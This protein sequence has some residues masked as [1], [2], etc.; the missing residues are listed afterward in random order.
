MSEIR[1][2]NRRACGAA[3]RPA[4][5]VGAGVS[6]V[7]IGTV[8]TGISVWTE[9]TVVP[10]GTVPIGTGGRVRKIRLIYAKTLF[11]VFFISKK[12]FLILNCLFSTVCVG[13]NYF[14]KNSFDN[15]S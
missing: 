15:L 6:E 10:I 1:R 9:L 8:R 3:L 2:N 13:S 7:S 5:T 4:A 11:S 14:Y 12:L